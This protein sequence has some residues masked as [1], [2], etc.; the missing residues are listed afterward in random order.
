MPEIPRAPV[1]E[2]PA[3][4]TPHPIQPQATAE[5]HAKTGPGALPAA[6]QAEKPEPKHVAPAAPAEADTEP[7]LPKPRSSIRPIHTPVEVYD[8]VAVASARANGK[9]VPV[10]KAPNYA[11]VTAVS[12]QPEPLVQLRRRLRQAMGREGEDLKLELQPA[13]GGQVL[14]LWPIAKREDATRLAETLRQAGIRMRVIE[15]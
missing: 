14:A 15:F 9:P 4:T 6:A 13:P 2:M 3:P 1:V 8:P 10:P 11:L 12:E 7:P 5:R